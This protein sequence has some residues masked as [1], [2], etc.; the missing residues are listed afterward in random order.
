MVQIIHCQGH[1]FLVHTVNIVDGEGA[2]YIAHE[3]W[4]C[5]HC[6]LKVKTVAAATELAGKQS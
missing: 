4:I 1:S 2:A 5:K 3:G 6:H